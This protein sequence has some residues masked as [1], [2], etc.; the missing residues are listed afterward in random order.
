[1]REG[2]QALIHP[3]PLALIAVDD[4]GEEV[5]AHFVDDH[6]DHAILRP[7]AVGTVLLG[8][9]TVEADHRILHADAIGMYTDRNGIDVI[10]GI[11]AVGLDG[12]RHHLGAVLLPQ[13]IALLRVVAHAEHVVLTNRLVHVRP[14]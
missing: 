11:L 7:L 10:A 5:V 2:V 6:A 3:R 8:P 13:W 14:R 9:T 12:V 1:L 4:H